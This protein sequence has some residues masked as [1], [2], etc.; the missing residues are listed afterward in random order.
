[1]RAGG[2][3]HGGGTR[4][5]AGGGGQSAAVGAGDDTLAAVVH[6]PVGARGDDAERAAEA[7]SERGFPRGGAGVRGKAEAGAVQGAVALEVAAGT[8]FSRHGRDSLI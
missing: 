5:G 6:G 3:A 4:A 8:G 2:A 1:P 7:A